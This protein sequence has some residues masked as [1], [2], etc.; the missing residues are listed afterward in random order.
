MV[1]DKSQTSGTTDNNVVEIP[2]DFISFYERFHT[3]SL[4]QVEHIIFPLKESSDSTMWLQSDWQ[5][6]RPFDSMNGEFVRSFDN[7]NG[8]IIE[9]IK[10]KNGFVEIT[11]RFGKIGDEYNLIYYRIRSQFDN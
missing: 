5:L 9:T 4:F 2:E 10:E 1:D 8:M 11:R 3:D 7:I 6:H